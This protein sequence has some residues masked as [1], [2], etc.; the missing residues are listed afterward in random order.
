MGIL[1]KSKKQL[2]QWQNLVVENSPNKLILNEAQLEKLSRQKAENSMRIVKDSSR[3]VST[4]VDPDTF[5]SRYEL[6][7]QHSYQLVL[8]SN[9]IKFKGIQ[10]Q[11]LYQQVQAQKQAEIKNILIR[12][13]DDVVTKAEKL[14]IPAAR[15]K[16]YEKLYKTL[17]RYDNEMNEENK[18]Y[19]K[20]RYN[21]ALS[22]FERREE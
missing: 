21:T 19:Y 9:Y 6:L 22:N 16:R 11:F 10:P 3:I 8:L 15:K 2:L 12:S 17:E 1:G 5:F 18:T 14:Q 20:C 4:T 7:T 13:W